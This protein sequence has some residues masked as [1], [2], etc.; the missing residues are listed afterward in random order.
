[1][2][3]D[4][5]ELLQQWN[6]GCPDAMA[7]VTAELA[8]DLRNLAASYMKGERSNHTLQPTALV[9]EL[10]LRLAQR[11]KV[12]WTDRGHFFAF[13][14]R[15]LRRILVDHA[16]KHRAEKRG[17][18]ESHVTLEDHIALT[19]QRDVDLLDLDRA[20]EELSREDRRMAQVIDMRFFAGMTIEETA[21]AMNLGTATVKRDLKMAR[22]FLLHRLK[23]EQLAA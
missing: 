2:K 10:Y 23:H 11:Q 4:V 14:S 3:N 5:T 17:G 15:T 22:A 18:E 7:K 6:D 8:D 21:A 16:R 9:S 20:L 13:A 12:H 19:A 1:M